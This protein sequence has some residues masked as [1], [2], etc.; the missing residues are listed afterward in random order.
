MRWKRLLKLFEEMYLVLQFRPFFYELR[1]SKVKDPF[2]VDTL[3][4]FASMQSIGVKLAIWNQRGTN[5]K[6]YVYIKKDI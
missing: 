5:K 3:Y 4:M 2:F 1:P 6:I